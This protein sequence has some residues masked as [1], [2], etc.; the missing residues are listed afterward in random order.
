MSTIRAALENLNSVIGTLE[1]SVDMMEQARKGEQ[2]DMFAAPSNENGK[3]TIDK[4]AVAK[5]LDN[6]I[7]KV[8]KLLG[9]ENVA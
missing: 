9:D 3:N 6:A 7:E 1:Q 4:E 8:E 5:R 2:R